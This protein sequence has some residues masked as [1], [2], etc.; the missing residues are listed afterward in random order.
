M[1]GWIETLVTPEISIRDTLARIEASELQIALVVDDERILQGVVTDGDV[2]R[3]ILRGISL[4]DPVGQ[5]MNRT[6]TTIHQHEDRETVV[7]LMQQERLHQVPVLDA[8][9]R[10]VGLEVI[11]D[12]LRPER[13]MNPV[14]IMA[15][16][17]GTRLRPLT[18]DSPKPL[19]KVGNKPILETILENFISCGF[20]R[21]YFSVNYKAEMIKAHFGNGEQWEVEIQYLHERKRLGTAGSL[22]L[23]PERP[24]EPLLVMNGDLLT[25]LNFV[26]LLDYHHDHQAVATMCVCEH[27]VQVPYGVVETEEQ[28]IV[29]IK[30]KPVQRFFINAG[31]YVLAPETLQYVPEDRFFDMPDLFEQLIKQGYKTAVFPI[32]EYWMDIGQMD[33]FKR[34]RDEVAG[35]GI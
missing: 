25:K 6:P 31:V 34:A 35:Q 7:A 24:N 16:G 23:L 9:G 33:D 12:L 26:H 17:I 1:N 14:V 29:S 32:R 20:Y 22:S 5:V 30:E 28:W 2:R 19:L 11:D 15:G 10:I 18:D 4:E 3:G 21:F 13:R 8:T 27:D